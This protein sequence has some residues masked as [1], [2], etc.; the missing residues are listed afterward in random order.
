MRC[1][2]WITLCLTVLALSNPLSAE[3]YRFKYTITWGI[4]TIYEVNLDTHVTADRYRIQST[5]RTKGVAALFNGSRNTVSSE[6]FLRPGGPQPTLYQSE[7]KIDGNRYQR[8][9][10]SDGFGRGV[11]TAAIWP[12]EWLDKYPREPVPEALRVGPDPLSLLVTLLDGSIPMDSVL[13]GAETLTFRSYDGRGVFD[14]QIECKPE[15]ETLSKSGKSIYE[16]PAYPCYMTQDLVAGKTIP[17]EAAKK[18]NAKRRKKE[19]KRRQKMKESE[20]DLEE[21]KPEDDR[22]KF[23]IAKPDGFDYFLPVRAS[24]KAGVGTIRVYLR[25]LDQGDPTMALETRTLNQDFCN[26]AKGDIPSPY[27]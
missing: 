19:E 5:G 22:L 21:D 14:V 13:Q 1:T 4:F 25:E 16:G 17:T 2:V 8:A 7:G 23:W 11:S 20:K 6:G 18:E 27:C 26:A 3:A 24:F 12:Q 10:F 9:L 15:R